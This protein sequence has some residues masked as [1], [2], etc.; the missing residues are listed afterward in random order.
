MSHLIVNKI[1]TARKLAA[2]TGSL[3]STKFVLGDIVSLKTRGLSHVISQQTH[4]DNKLNLTSHKF[5]QEEI[6]FWESNL[7]ALNCKPFRTPLG[8]SQLHCFL[9]ASNKAL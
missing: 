8:T 3:V 1:T 2:F 5:A 7:S 6:M 4:W 9:N